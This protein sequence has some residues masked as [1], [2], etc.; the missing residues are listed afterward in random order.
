MFVH[1]KE[2]M[3][4]QSCIGRGE[5]EHGARMK[6]QL[7][8]RP[9]LVRDCSGQVNDAADDIIPFPVMRQK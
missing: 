8:P 3:T 9:S 7:L 6:S 1:R 2:N 5:G 4:I